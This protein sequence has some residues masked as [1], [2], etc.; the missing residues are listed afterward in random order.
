MREGDDRAEPAA[1][2]RRELLLGLREPAGGD[3]GAL[4]LE[5][6]RLSGREGIELGCAVEG[7]RRELLFLP[8]RPHCFR[9]PD[10]VGRTGQGRHEVVR[11]RRLVIVRERR[12]GQVGAALRRRVDHGALDRVQRALREGRVGAHR[13]DLVAEQLETERLAAGGREDVDDPAANRELAP[14]LGSLDALVAREGES[15]RQVL[16]RVLGQPDR[17]R[18]LLGRWQAFGDRG[19]RGRDEAAGGE[20][21]ERPGPL[22]DEV[23]RRLEPGAP[24]NAAARQ[25]RDAVVTEEPGGRL[26]RVAR[27]G[28][29]GEDD[30]EA[31]IE[32]EVESR[33]E[34]RQRGLGDPRARPFAVRRLDGEALVRF[35]D[36]V[37]ERPKPLAFG[38]LLCNDV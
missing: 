23:R 9:L 16:L 33:E 14:F 12:F 17:L 32:P 20:D 3:R 2:E 36:L 19:R 8:D 21:V 37:G 27:V 35:G 18:A 22:T 38:E 26:G 11:G 6:D 25:E 13:L 28:V 34:E 31:T 1:D 4:R 29:L 7:L 5:R 15:L 10:E 30:H 24:T